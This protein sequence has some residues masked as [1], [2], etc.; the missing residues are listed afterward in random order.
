[1][2]RF[3]GL[4]KLTRKKQQLQGDKIKGDSKECIFEFLRVFWRK[5]Q[6]Q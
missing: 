3:F 2:G 4:K 5:M 6:E 1:M